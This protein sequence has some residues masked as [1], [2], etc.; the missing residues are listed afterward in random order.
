MWQR[1][2]AV[3]PSARYTDAAGFASALR[4]ALEAPA[5]E[6]AFDKSRGMVS[7]RGFDGKQGWEVAKRARRHG[8]L[9]R[10]LGDTVYLVPPLNVGEDDLEAM[11]SAVAVAL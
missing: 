5:G 1:S 2:V 6:G 10:P 3:D 7:E 11:L 8:I 9:L 4:G